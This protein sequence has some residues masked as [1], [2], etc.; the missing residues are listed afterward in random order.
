[1]VRRDFYKLFDLAPYRII[2]F[3]LP[4]R[5]AEVS[6]VFVLYIIILSKINNSTKLHITID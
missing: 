1:M 5:D 3:V 2:G 4:V 6:Q